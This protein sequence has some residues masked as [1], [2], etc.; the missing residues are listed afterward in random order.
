MEPSQQEINSNSFNRE[1]LHEGRGQ[2]PQGIC[3]VCFDA[4]RRFEHKYARH[5]Y[6]IDRYSRIC[7]HSHEQSEI[8]VWLRPVESL[9]Q[10]IE[11]L[12]GQMNVFEKYPVSGLGS[13]VQCEF[14]FTNALGRTHSNRR[15][16]NI[17]LFHQLLY[18]VTCVI[19]RHRY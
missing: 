9:F 15:A 17:G 3:D 19:A 5:T 7:L 6:Q 14:G 13:R 10:V 18:L 12:G 8:R 16:A 1:F 4:W 2:P 11:P